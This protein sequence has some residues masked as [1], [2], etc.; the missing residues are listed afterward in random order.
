MRIIL[1]VLL[2]VI[3]VGYASAQP[4]LEDFAALPSAAQVEISPNGEL[5]AV[6]CSPRGVEEICVY[7]LSGETRPRL[8]PAPEGARTVGMFWPSDTH[9]VFEIIQHERLR[10]R[11]GV[12]GV[13]FARLLAWREETGE[14][15]VLLNDLRGALNDL[16]DIATTLVDESDQMAIRGAFGLSDASHTGSMTRRTMDA[17]TVVWR[18]DLNTGRSGRLLYDSRESIVDAVFDPHGVLLA[19]VRFRDEAGEY[20]IRAEGEQDQVIYRGLHPIDF[21]LIY[22]TMDEGAAL[23]VYFPD[24]EGL[25]RLDLETG[26]RTSFGARWVQAEPVMDRVTGELLG[27]GWIDDLPRRHFIDADLAELQSALSAVLP[28]DSVVLESWTPDRSKIIVVGRDIGRPATFY[29]FDRAAG[30]VNVVASQSDNLTNLPLA[31]VESFSYQARDGMVIPAYLTL[32]TGLTRTDGPFPLIVMPHGGPQARDT[33]AY[34]WEAAY[35]A[36][37]GYAVLR[38]NFRGSGGLGQAHLEA[39]YG[40]Y[41][42][43]MI[44]DMMDG[45]RHLQAEGVARDDGYCAM[46]ASYGGYAALMLG[47]DDAEQVRCVVGVSSVTDPLRM[48]ADFRGDE[49]TVDYLE[50][51]MGS[52]FSTENETGRYAPLA[53]VREF[54]QPVLLI[55]GDADVQ[56]PDSHSTRM[57]RERGRDDSFRLVTIEDENHYF[58]STASRTILLQEVTAFLDQHLPVD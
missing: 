34:N 13:R 15:V 51:Y 28:E 17:Q 36:S 33:G 54:T 58:G 48:M 12:D 31:S 38:P 5:I 47:L 14:T 39:G 22:G 27:F 16:T 8:I 50:R 4:T 43:G 3:T 20:I 57:I 2:T 55:H 18:V 30:A 23:V 6:A 10:T 9:L 49:A 44:Q 26:V 37:L 45:A 46:G 25:M 53:R 32:P 7:D 1:S 56:V 29:L 21:P 40:E 19:D 42:R 41:G 52:R 35:L 11:S 24:G